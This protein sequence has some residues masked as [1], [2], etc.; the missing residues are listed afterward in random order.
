M[1]WTALSMLSPLVFAIGL[2]DYQLNKK[3]CERYSKLLVEVGYPDSELLEKLDRAI[4]GEKV[5]I[6]LMSGE[7]ITFVLTILF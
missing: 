5:G 2:I 6:S 1:N 7:I 3:R 4:V